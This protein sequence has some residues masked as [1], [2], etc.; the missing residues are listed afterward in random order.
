MT[1]GIS[2]ELGENGVLAPGIH[3]STFEDVCE[4][5]IKGFPE[6]KTRDKIYKEFLGFINDIF[7]RY[8]VYEVWIDGSFSTAK[9]NPNDIDLV[10]FL[11]VESFINIQ[12]EWATLRKQANLDPYIAVAVCPDTQ[13]KVDSRVYMDVINK[14]NYWRGQFGYDRND[15]P[16]GIISIKEEELENLIKGGDLQCL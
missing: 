7:N 6:S 8:K 4:T 1:G 11:Y 12:S 14:R 9:V 15:V 3:T 16:K 5:F 2:V 10:L 13:S